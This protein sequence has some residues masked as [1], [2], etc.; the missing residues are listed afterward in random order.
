[1]DTAI[2]RDRL[3]AEVVTEKRL[4]KS[5]ARYLADEDNPVTLAEFT[6]ACLSMMLGHQMA[7]REAAEHT[8]GM[9]GAIDEMFSR[10]DPQYAGDGKVREALDKQRDDQRRMSTEQRAKELG[11][12]E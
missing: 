4:P 7:A 6:A 5:W 12:P 2:V 1:M 8:E 9:L 3:G 10:M 11:R